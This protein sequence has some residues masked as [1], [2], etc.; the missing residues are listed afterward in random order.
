M[1]KEIQQQNTTKRVEVCENYIMLFH[2][3]TSTA[4]LYNGCLPWYNVVIT[5]RVHSSVK[6]RQQSTVTRATVE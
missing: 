5:L 3:L 2:G 1:Y 6:N 4:C